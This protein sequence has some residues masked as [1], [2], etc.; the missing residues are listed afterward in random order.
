MGS[1]CKFEIKKESSQWHFTLIA[2]NQK[3]ILSSEHYKSKSACENGIKSVKTNSKL[4][5]HY[6][7]LT[8][9]KGQPY[10][11]LIAGNNKIIGNSQMYKS[12]AECNTA[13]T[14]VKREAKAAPIVEKSAKVKKQPANKSKKQPVS[15]TQSIASIALVEAP[16]PFWRFL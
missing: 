14:A 11:V 12:E 7:K 8:S 15:L 5:T 6:K 4:A 9:K 2:D 16:D 10:F 1:K 13:I 3:T